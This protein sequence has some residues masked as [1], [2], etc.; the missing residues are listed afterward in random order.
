MMDDFLVKREHQLLATISR[1]YKKKGYDVK[2]HPTDEDLPDFLAGLAPDLLAKGQ[3]ENVVVEVKSRP[4]L[5]DQRL[6]T[7]AHAIE[8]K[9]G[10]RFELAVA[11][12]DDTERF[13]EEQALAAPELKA[14]ILESLQLLDKGHPEAALLLLWSAAEGVIRIRAKQGGLHLRRI[15]S[16]YLLKTVFAEGLCDRTEYDELMRTFQIRNE[17]VHGYRP[18]Q[19]DYQMIRRLA[20]M[21]GQFGEI[22]K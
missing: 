8:G 17:I 2:I 22:K 12:T 14:R 13:A 9:T 5:A 1:N 19:F 20:T 18:M 11:P 10:W 16:A 4:D 6:T 7:I 3:G 15:S 21:I